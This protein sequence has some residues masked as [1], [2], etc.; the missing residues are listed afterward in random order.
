MK[1]WTLAIL[2]IAFCATRLASASVT[3][4]GLTE[5]KIRLSKVGRLHYDDLSDDE[6]LQLFQK[7]VT[8]TQRMV[9]DCNDVPVWVGKACNNWS[10]TQTSNALY[11]VLHSDSTRPQV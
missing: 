3:S 1:A 10:V 6:K 9:G 4:V 2:S 5:E 8:D 7:Y 11:H